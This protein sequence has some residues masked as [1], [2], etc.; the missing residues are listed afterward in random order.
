[1]PHGRLRSSLATFS[2]MRGAS[3]TVSLV[4]DWP[5]RHL[6]WTKS[7][8]ARRQLKKVNC[9]LGK[10]TVD[11]YYHRANYCN[12]QAL[13]GGEPFKELQAIGQ[14][15]NGSTSESTGR[16]CLCC[17]NSNSGDACRRYQIP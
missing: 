11:S 2:V 3:L 14:S 9:D 13:D 10:K 4:I 7:P 8:Q 16:H 6:H 17:N 12:P 1:M 5:R 15:H